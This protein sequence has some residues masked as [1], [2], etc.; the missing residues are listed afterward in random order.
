MEWKYLQRNN[1]F[2]ACLHVIWNFPVKPLGG[3]QC[4]GGILCKKIFSES[5]DTYLSKFIMKIE[6]LRLFHE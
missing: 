5:I 6:I 1:D 2:L 3:W 4:I